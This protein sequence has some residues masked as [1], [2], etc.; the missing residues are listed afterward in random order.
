MIKA[1]R[2]GL[3]CRARAQAGRGLSRFRVIQNWNGAGGCTGPCRNLA[4]EVL[5]ATGQ[6]SES[7][8]ARGSSLFPELMA[9]SCQAV[10]PGRRRDQ[11]SQMLMRLLRNKR[12][13]RASAR[14]AGRF[15]CNT[16]GRWIAWL[17]PRSRVQA[18]SPDQPGDKGA[19]A[20]NV[21]IVDRPY[22]FRKF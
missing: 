8:D 16:S 21:P 22:F 18:P 5:V 15:M 9:R 3:G 4:C 13:V 17:S 20:K 10:S 11:G 12:A 6:C 7:Y 19:T 2:V 14:S 1:K